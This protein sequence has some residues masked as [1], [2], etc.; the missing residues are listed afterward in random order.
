MT[1]PTP[2]ARALAY[3]PARMRW[4]SLPFV[5]LLV[6]GLLAT[7][8]VSGC[9]TGESALQKKLD[10][11]K[12]ARFAK[13]RQALEA[14]ETAR[15][16]SLQD[17]LPSPDAKSEG[18]KHPIV[19]W[20]ASL[21]TNTDE[22][23]LL[24]LAEEYKGTPTEDPALSGAAYAKTTRDFWKASRGMK[25]YKAFLDGYLT[26][27]EARAAAGKGDETFVPTP[28]GDEARFDRVFLHAFRF[29]Q[30]ERLPP[31]TRILSA[32][33]FWQLAFDFP[34]IPRESF[35]GY[36]TRICRSKVLRDRCSSVPHELRPAAINKPYLEWSK[37]QATDYLAKGPV[38]PFK[39]VMDR[40]VASL[41]T[42]LEEQ[43]D[44]TEDPVLPATF[45]ARAASRG[46]TLMA[47]EK[48]GVMLHTT[49]VE[50]SFEG[51]IPASLAE[52][53]AT[54]IQQL[55]DTPGNQ[56]DFERVVVEVPAIVS[57]EGFRRVI[58]SFPRDIVRQ[59]DLVGRRRAD[60][61]LRRT[62]VLVRTPA[63][64]EGETTSYTFKDQEKVRCD[65]VGVAGRPPIGRKAPGSY[66]VM[67]KARIRAAKLSRDEETRELSAG[68]YT[69]DV[70]TSEAAAVQ[71]WADKNPGIVRF[72]ISD[73]F[74]YDEILQHMSS[75]LYKCTDTEFALD[76]RGLEQITITCGKTDERD[77]TLVVGLCE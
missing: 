56:I 67:D 8:A 38:D 74:S 16:A 37:S 5:A 4:A 77:I 19:L 35:S 39:D 9:D 55:K 33:P 71:E 43:P 68:E 58:Q 52:I 72:F 49:K 75:V 30:L 24:A 10:E 21:E 14:I 50:E 2:M 42:A 69:L 41:D 32:F 53:A 40:Y 46:L 59:F 76:E 20:R 54:T 18:R 31:D 60:G 3:R 13:A 47:S 36:V 63:P 28:F 66:L 26:E 7:V 64:D 57:G 6:L 34:S 22:A 73:D 25:R 61:S 45:S 27:A 70:S 48:I 1:R 17:K 12:A 62:G 65:Y 51:R 29:F 23:K 11:K 15:T 44:L